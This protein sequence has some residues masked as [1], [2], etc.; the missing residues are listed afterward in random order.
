MLPSLLALACTLLG[1]LPARAD[2][3]PPIAQRYRLEATLEPRQHRVQ[4]KLSLAFTNSSRVPLERLVFHLYLNAFRDARSV[5]MRESG[6]ALRG[7]RAAGHGQLLLSGLRVAGTDR[8]G[9]AD[10]QLVAGDFTQLS[11]PLAQPLASGAS[12]TIEA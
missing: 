6:G 11:V 5:F 9:E 7:T 1:S 4:G 8:L 12:V 3:D 10:P 2:A